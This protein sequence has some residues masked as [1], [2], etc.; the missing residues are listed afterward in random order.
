MIQELEIYV[1]ECGFSAIQA[2]R[3]ATGVAAECFGLTDRGR[4]MVGKRADLVLC[5]GDVTA[6]VS[7]LRDADGVW[8]G[9]LR[10]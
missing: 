3:A 9:G 4:V 10:L 8:R 5:M 2:L 1:S 7:A 6:D